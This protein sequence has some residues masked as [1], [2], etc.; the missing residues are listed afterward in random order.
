[1]SARG[2]VA[3]VLV[4]VLGCSS[5]AS[6]DVVEAEGGAGA[7]GAAGAGNGETD[8]AI[9]AAPDP[10]AVLGRPCAVASTCEVLTEHAGTVGI[11]G[12]ERGCLG[13]PNPDGGPNLQLCSFRCAYWTEADK[14]SDRRALCEAIGGT[15]SLE[16]GL[17]YLH[18]EPEL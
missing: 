18:C 16:D 17:G 5:S 14:P 11:P 13:F 6:R 9:D 12:A 2:L 7:A 8:A 15:C 3:V 4:G 1:M 10:S